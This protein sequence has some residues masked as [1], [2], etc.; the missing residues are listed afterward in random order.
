MQTTIIA[1]TAQDTHALGERIGHRLVAG[2]T[3]LLHGELGAGK[4]A[5]CRGIAQGLGIKGSITS[6]TFTIVN[7]YPRQNGKLIH[8]DQYRITQAAFWEMGLDEY[9]DDVN[10]V[11]VEW[12]REVPP[13]CDALNVSILYQ[14]GGREITICSND[15]NGRWEGLNYETSGD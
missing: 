15:Q 2:D 8:M 1:K 4:T 9:W 12:P 11:V 3:V 7:E 13:L 6:P 5:L 10:I 14:N